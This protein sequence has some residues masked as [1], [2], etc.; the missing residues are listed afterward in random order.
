MDLVNHIS[1]Y[2]RAGDSLVPP[3][4]AVAVVAALAVPA[5]WVGAQS[6]P[7]YRIVESG[8]YIDRIPPT[9]FGWADNE[10]FVFKGVLPSERDQTE[11]ASPLIKIWDTAKNSVTPYKNLRHACFKD[12]KIRY[13]EKGNE[14]E[15]SGKYVWWEGPLGKERRF[16]KANEPRTSDS[17]FRFATRPKSPFHCGL[18]FRDELD[19]PTKD[20]SRNFIVL[21]DGDGYLDIGTN[22]V[23][24]RREEQ[25][26][27]RKI[28]W[29]H[30]R[31]P[32]GKEL[33]I[34]L[35]Y[36]FGLTLPRYSS[37]ANNYVLVP[38]APS[39]KTEKGGESI[40]YVLNPGSLT[41]ERRSVPRFAPS[42][43]FTQGRIEFGKV[44]VVFTGSGDPWHQWAGIYLFSDGKVTRIERGSMTDL[45]VSPDGCKVAYAIQTRN[46]EMGTPIEVKLTNICSRR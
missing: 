1:G 37:F 14:P 20:A 46:T 44:G 12:R 10:R 42:G 36:D 16:E 45:N 31:V 32:Q 11:L 3:L 21:R 35:A 25:E 39:A 5:Q 2:A 15:K 22:L 13:A 18:I 4:A 41:A 40:Y 34:P 38:S 17:E 43:G 29:Y 6:M 9:V 19:P 33:N 27:G 23:G 7:A 26:F 8:Y 30:P 28:L 24:K